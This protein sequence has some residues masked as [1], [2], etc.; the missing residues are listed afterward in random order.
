MPARAIAELQ[1]N[2]TFKVKIK[3]FPEFLMDEPV[4]FHGNDRGPSSIE[5]LCTAVAGCNGTSFKFCLDKFGIEVNKMIVIAEA[6]MHHVDVDGRSLLRITNLHVKIDVELKNKDDEEDLL[7]CFDV[8]KKYCVVSGSIT[9][10]IP[11]D[12]SLNHK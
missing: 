4:E 5:F 1:D 2:I 10:G 11:M 6:E 8:Y 12:I 9:K 3:D 7:E